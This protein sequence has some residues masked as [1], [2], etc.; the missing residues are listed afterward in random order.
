MYNFLQEW[1]F[2]EKEKVET[3]K[4]KLWK[5]DF[6]GPFLYVDVRV[7]KSGSV[8]VIPYLNECKEN[9]A[10]NAKT[11]HDILVDA[12]EELLQMFGTFTLKLRGKNWTFVVESAKQLEKELVIRERMERLF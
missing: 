5:T 7:Y 6:Y 8:E 12:S 9:P 3:A 11:D 1:H 4:I 10:L 2:D